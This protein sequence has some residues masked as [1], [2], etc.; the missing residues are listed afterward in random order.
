MPE[1]SSRMLKFIQVN[2]VLSVLNLCYIN[3]HFKLLNNLILD[4][5]L[6]SNVCYFFCKAEHVVVPIVNTF[7]I[8]LNF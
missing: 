5:G 7:R 2:H 4:L 6:P 3:L 1:E 8:S